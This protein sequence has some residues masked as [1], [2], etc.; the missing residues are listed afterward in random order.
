MEK[1][2]K[3]LFPITLIL[4]FGLLFFDNIQW[5]GVSVLAFF[6]PL[7]LLYYITFFKRSISNENVNYRFKTP[8]LIFL[9]ITISLIPIEVIFK[10]MHYPFGSLIV[11]ASY[12]TGLLTIVFGVIY[13]VLNRNNLYRVSYEFIVLII[14]VVALSYNFINNSVKKD[15][16]KDF[17]DNY[18]SLNY[19]KIRLKN[20]NSFS[21]PR[22]DSLYNQLE[23]AKENLIVNTGGV[24]ENGII[25]GWMN[26]SKPEYLLNH[27]GLINQLMI[28]NYVTDF[29]KKNLREAKTVM[30]YLIVFT[31]IQNE[32]LLN[33]NKSKVK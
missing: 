6:Q 3:I 14:P 7:I 13:L 24:N 30:N 16:V 1:A 31:N 21:D 20:Q 11:I 32:L 4:G 5:I 25:I 29:N 33:S 2:F 22:K 8:F 12:F 19:I 23:K 26:K 17:H 27:S 10:L 28:S 9:I 15:F 18:I